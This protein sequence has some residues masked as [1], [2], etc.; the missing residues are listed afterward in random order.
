VQWCETPSLKF[1]DQDGKRRAAFATAIRRYWPDVRE[2]SLVPGYTGIRPKISGRGEPAADFAIHGPAE[3]GLDGLVA[4]YGIESPGLTSS[5]AIG[6]LV[7][8]M[9]R[10]SASPQG[11][12]ARSTE[13][14]S[15]H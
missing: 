1:D 3:H 6:D 11:E 12:S 7:A 10:P 2:E 15:E 9:L 5:L 4:L 13:C 8:A 14:T